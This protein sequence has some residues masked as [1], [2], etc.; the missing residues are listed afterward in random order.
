[1]LFL[2][3]FYLISAYPNV[4]TYIATMVVVCIVGEF[5]GIVNSTVVL[6][7]L[8]IQ[9]YGWYRNMNEGGRVLLQPVFASCLQFIPRTFF[10]VISSMHA[11]V[12][13]FLWKTQ[14]LKG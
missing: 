11:I 14:A 13:V 12:Y 8:T 10:I 3:V 7:F 1:M 6:Q 4:F 9:E 2:A 5:Q